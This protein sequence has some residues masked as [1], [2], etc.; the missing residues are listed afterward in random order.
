MH[1]VAHPDDGDL[2]LAHRPQQRRK[3]LAH[4]LRAHPR[5]QRQAARDAAGIEPLGERDRVLGRRRRAE[6]DPDRVADAG[7]ELDVR[8]AEI[9]RALA[10]PEHVRRAVVPLRR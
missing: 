6:L 5:D 7:E 4:A 9:A 1:R 2:R 8:A 3:R 10:D